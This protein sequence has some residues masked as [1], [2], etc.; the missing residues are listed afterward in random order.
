M[1]EMCIF[2]QKI[3]FLL[4]ENQ[5]KFFTTFNTKIL[6]PRINLKRQVSSQ[7]ITKHIIFEFLYV[8]LFISMCDFYVWM[9]T[10]YNLRPRPQA[11]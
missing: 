7:S 5:I 11:L 1:I 4:S 6:S 2:T 10:V 3:L 8:S 9:S